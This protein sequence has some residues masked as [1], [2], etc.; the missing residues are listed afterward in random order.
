MSSLTSWLTKMTVLC[1]TALLFACSSGNN[2]SSAPVVTDYNGNHPADWVTSHYSAYKTSIAG[3][4]TSSCTECHGSDLKGGISKVSCFTAQLAN[5]MQCHATRLGHP[6]NWANPTMHGKAG[7]MGA[8]GLSTGFAYC[9][10][11]HGSDLKGGAGK[12]VSC[13][14]CHTS[15]PHPAKPWI[16]GGLTHATTSPANAALCFQCHAGGS[17]YGAVLASTPLPS[18]P[19]APTPDCF[20]NT[21]CHGGNVAPPHVKGVAYMQGGQHGAD[22]AGKNS[23]ELGIATCRSCHAGSGARFNLGTNNMS[24]GCETCHAAYTAHPTPWLPARAGSSSEIPKPGGVP[25]TTSHATVPVAQLTTSCTMCHGAALD[26]IGAKGNAPSCLSA[27]AK[28]GISCHVSSPVATPRGCASCH[29]ATPTSGAHAKHLALP[30]VTCDA[31]HTGGGVDA[32]TSL[33]RALH[34][35][36]TVNVASAGYWGKTGTFG[37]N[38]DKTCSNVRCHGGGDP[39]THKT[40]AWTGTLNVAECDKCHEQGNS[41]NTPQTPQFNS[42]YSGL[43]NQVTP[44]VNLHQFHITAGYACTE[45][46]TMTETNHFSG[47]ASPGF[48]APGNTVVSAKITGGY[49]KNLARC[50]GVVCHTVVPPTSLWR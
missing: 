17:N 24:N 12:A 44:A 21:M 22:A 19:A 5:G 39:V 42:Y 30:G 4:A 14:S 15:A 43:Y 31:C 18:S 33:G 50:S 36:G 8:P 3:G 32:T 6:E 28:F 13:Y 16:G 25:N 2:S 11:C 9:A 46:H 7:A 29:V 37:L 27:S 35:N 1:A 20:N 47:L 40:P 41:G 10:T 38:S 49:D 48:E 34:A 45:C 26:G 23:P